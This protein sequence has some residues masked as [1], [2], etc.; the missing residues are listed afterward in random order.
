MGHWALVIGNWELVVLLLVPLSPCLPIP[1]AILT[2]VKKPLP[3]MKILLINDDEQFTNQLKANLKEHRYLVDTA[4]DGQEGWE[5]E[6]Q[7]YDLIVLDLMLPRLDG[8]TFC[9]RLRAKDLQVLV[10][11]LTVRAASED[12]IN[13][14]DAGADDYVVKPVPLPELTARIRA[15][16][17][18]KA[19][20]VSTVLEWGNLSLEAKTG[21]VRY[22]DILLHLTKKEYSLLELFMQD[23]IKIYSQNSILNQLWTFEDEPPTRDAIRTLVKRLRQKIIFWI[24]DFRFWILD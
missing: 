16:L 14:L 19:T 9:S 5:F 12:K 3:A 7:E 15:L 18:R 24:L 23:P 21:E 17:R 10:M 13:G 6:A 11:F 20:S 1:W 22:S 2:Q 4:I 8:I